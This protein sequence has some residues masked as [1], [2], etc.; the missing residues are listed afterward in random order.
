MFSPKQDPIPLH[1]YNPI[2]HTSNDEPIERHFE[3]I[4]N[5]K[6]YPDPHY[7]SIVTELNTIHC[8]QMTGKKPLGFVCLFGVYRPTRE[9]FTHME[10]S[11]LSMKGCKF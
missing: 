10:T 9:F 6:K 5:K 8:K 2:H 7:S 1:R 3:D 4:I 11:P